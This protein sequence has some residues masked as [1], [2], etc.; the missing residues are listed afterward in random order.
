MSYIPLR[1]KRTETSGL[2][3][4]GVTTDDAILFFD[5]GADITDEIQIAFPVDPLDGQVFG[6]TTRKA[7]SSV[8]FTSQYY[9]I[10]AN[11]TSISPDSP[12]LW[13]YCIESEKWF[14]HP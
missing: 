5:T 3:D 6:V 11:V 12:V 4:H 1:S 10:I 13:F 2:V 8:V 7:I 14:R 9:P